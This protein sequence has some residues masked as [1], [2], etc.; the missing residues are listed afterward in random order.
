MI[1]K[2]IWKPILVMTAMV[3]LLLVFPGASRANLVIG[4]G[5]ESPIVPQA[6]QYLIY[7]TPT[8]W[9]GTGDIVVQGYSGAV[10]S[11]DWEQWFDLNPSYDMGTGISQTIFLNAGTTYIFSFLYNGG[12]GG[13]TSEISFSLISGLETLFSGLVSTASMNVYNGTLW[14]TY[15]STFIP[16]NS[17]LDTLSFVPNGSWSGGFIDA[18]TISVIPE[19]ATLLL[20]GLGALFLRRKK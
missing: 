1:K 7:A 15:S 2:N 13:T 11:G 14:K 5:F 6:S 19:P 12:G 20:L 16:S 10:S 18:V 9:S 8:G 17:G 3:A 4:G